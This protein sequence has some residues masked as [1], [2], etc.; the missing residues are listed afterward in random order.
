[1]LKIEINGT[2]FEPLAYRSYRPTAEL[3]RGFA[4]TGLRLANVTHTGMLCTLDVP[5]SLFG[6]AWTG[7]EQFDWKAFDG[8]WTCSRPMLRAR[9]TTSHCSSIPAIS[10]WPASGVFEQLLEPGRDRG[11]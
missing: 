10:T 11:P 2:I 5:Y 8:K 1:M 9:T 6:E 4:G 7:P 3:V